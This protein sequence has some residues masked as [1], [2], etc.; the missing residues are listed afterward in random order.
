MHFILFVTIYIDD[1]DAF[2]LDIY[3]DERSWIARLV[4]SAD[5]FT[6]R[7]FRLSPPL[8]HRRRTITSWRSAKCAGPVPATRLIIID[9]TFVI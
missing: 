7:R 3:H 9:D 1:D 4:I 6:G 8:T 5:Y 2:S